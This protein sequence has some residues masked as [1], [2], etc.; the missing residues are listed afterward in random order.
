MTTDLVKFEDIG[1]GRFRIVGRLD[2]DSVVQALQTSQHLFAELHAIQL[3]LSGVSTIDSAGLA[4]IIEWIS[5]ARRSKCHLSFRN[6]PKQ[7][8]ALARISDIEKL[9][10]FAP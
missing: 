6:M 4:L 7:A 10:P 8:L 1:A 3:D 9:L 2:F 5:R